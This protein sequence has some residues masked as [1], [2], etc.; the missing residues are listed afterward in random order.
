VNAGWFDFRPNA[1]AGAIVDGGVPVD[2]ITGRVVGHAP[3]VGAYERGDSSYWIPGRRE[4]KASAP[5]VPDQARGVPVDRDVL[6]WKP[7]YQAVGHTVFFAAS[8]EDLSKSAKGRRFDGEENIFPLPKLLG[9][10]KYY[11]RVDAWMP[12]GS[13]KTGDIWSFST[14]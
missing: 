5:I 9:G 12:D 10:R 11:W 13:V 14:R 8:K 6:M 4:L 2:G 1:S 3:D 7:A